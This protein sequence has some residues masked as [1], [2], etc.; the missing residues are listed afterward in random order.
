MPSIKELMTWEPTGNGR[1]V[2]KHRNKRYRIGVKRL[3][4]LHPDLVTT[5]SRAGTRLAANQ[6][7]TDQQQELR[8]TEN[9]DSIL[10]LRILLE[11]H[12]TDLESAKVLGDQ[13]LVSIIEERIRVLKDRLE[14]GRPLEGV[15]LDRTAREKSEAVV[16]TSP[17]SPPSIELLRRDL[18]EM[19]WRRSD[20]LYAILPV[21][22]ARIAMES[23]VG[24]SLRSVVDLFLE[25]RKRDA[26]RKP[27]DGMKPISVRR[28]SA[29]KGHLEDL[30]SFAGEGMLIEQ[31]NHPQ[32]LTM[33]HTNVLD[34]LESGAI[35]STY[36]ARDYMA[37]A[38][39][40][41]RWC[42]EEHVTDELPRNIDS[43]KLQIQL[44]NSETV[45][46]EVQ[47]LR[48]I[49]DVATE[50]TKL[51]LLL[52]ANCGFRQADISDLR[53]YELNSNRIRHARVK[54]RKKNPP[55][56]NYLLWPETASLLEAYLAG[57]ERSEDERVFVNENGGPLKVETFSGRGESYIDNIR[58]AYWRV[59]DK[60]DIPNGDRKP[61]SGIRA[62][63]A[64]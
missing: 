16:I 49:I 23:P 52:M 60:L 24:R 57:K 34:R 28:Y 51:F 20:E 11:E 29:L 44:E 32:T 54:T 30:V 17:N 46:F 9:P 18:R 63:S 15:E 35:G 56:V 38:K 33:Y 61:L 53:M 4:Q 45:V 5:L 13:R 58:S 55:I 3:Q 42:Y 43:K 41:F 2:K 14:S 1:W 12:E 7:W 19:L 21:K 26:M 36:T 48:K 50:R 6:W 39:Q 31:A 64:D 27:V 62:T 25:H 40:F 59:L 47:E 22:P 37:T 10:V 8:L